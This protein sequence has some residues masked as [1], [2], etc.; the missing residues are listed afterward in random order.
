MLQHI[1]ALGSSWTMSHRG[2]I[3][4]R[5]LPEGEQWGANNAK[6]VEQCAPA[7]ALQQQRRH[8]QAQQ[9]AYDWQLVLI[10]L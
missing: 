5:R 4:H 8:H 2:I 7:K 6:D 10:Q 9:V 1:S 3:G